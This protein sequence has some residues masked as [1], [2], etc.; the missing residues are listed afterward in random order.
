MFGILNFT[1]FTSSVQ[2]Q[3]F[4]CTNHMEI[5]P[6]SSK[7]YVLRNSHQQSVSLNEVLTVVE[8]GLAWVDDGEAEQEPHP[9]PQ[10]VL[11]VAVAVQ[12]V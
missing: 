5:K 7:T 4:Y 2:A 11:V 12:Q 9:H 6:I 8:V 1:S 10:H 3:N